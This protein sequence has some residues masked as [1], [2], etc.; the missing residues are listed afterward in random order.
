MKWAK[1]SEYHAI[2]DC[3]RYKVAVWYSNGVPMYLLSCGDESLGWHKT[4]KA[5]Q[6]AAEKHKGA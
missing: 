6:R 1:R 4:S 3:K 5:A 2:S